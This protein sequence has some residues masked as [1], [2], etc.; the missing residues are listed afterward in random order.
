ME[1]WAGAKTKL[2]E[3]IISN[4]QSSFPLIGISDD[5]FIV[6]GKVLNKMRKTFEFPP[7]RRRRITWDILIAISASENNAL[8]ITENEADFSRIKTFIEFNFIGI[9]NI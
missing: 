4:H 8:L 9:E 1:L 6:A 2:E 7:E 5:N 3:K